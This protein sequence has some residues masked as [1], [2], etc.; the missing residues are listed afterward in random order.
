M[1]WLL[2]AIIATFKSYPSVADLAIESSLL[3]LFTP[4]LTGITFRLLFVVHVFIYSAAFAWLTWGAW[5]FHG[6]GN[7]NFYY[8]TNL[9]LCAAQSWLV[10]E[11]VRQLL[12]DDYSLKPSST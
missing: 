7:A 9:G 8:G 6:S 4:L 11:A 12:D 5:I 10:V 3:I 2:I 1:F